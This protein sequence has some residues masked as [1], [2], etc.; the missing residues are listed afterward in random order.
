MPKT[1]LRVGLVA[2]LVLALHA[3][4]ARAE[5]GNS[6]DPGFYAGAR[7]PACAV[8]VEW[9]NLPPPEKWSVLHP[10]EALLSYQGHT[11]TR[12]VNRR[13]QDLK[14]LKRLSCLEVNNYRYVVLDALGACVDYGLCDGPAYITVSS[15]SGASWSDLKALVFH[16]SGVKYDF[17]AAELPRKLQILGDTHGF[18]LA[19]YFLRQRAVMIASADLTPLRFWPAEELLWCGVAH[20]CPLYFFSGRIYFISGAQ[21]RP[22]TFLNVSSDYGRTWTKSENEY[23]QESVFFS[24]DSVLYHV[25][26]TPA[27]AG[28]LFLIPALGEVGRI[29]RLRYLQANGD[30]S[31]PVVVK[32][33]V[34]RLLN[35]QETASPVIYWEDARLLERRVCGFIPVIGCVDSGPFGGDAVMYRGELDLKTFQLREQLLPGRRRAIE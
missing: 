32:K 24:A 30:W 3:S 7:L 33:K 5:A 21:G 29:L 20:P 26:T 22:H 12:L 6:D 19:F 8:E 14:I 16:E 18:A 35:V 1:T 15:D 23:L 9:R 34:L 27:D 11:I 17:V 25:Y 10:A 13:E 4:C 28:A 2:A 31:E